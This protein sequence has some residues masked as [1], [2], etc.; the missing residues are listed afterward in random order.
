MWFY[1]KLAWRNIFRN[2]RRTIIASIAI[3]IGLASLIFF[4]ALLIGMK[5]N[6]I[7]SATST[8][9][10]EAQIHRNE[11]RETQEANLTIVKSEGIIKSLGKEEIVEAFTPRTLSFGMLSSPANVNAVVLAGIEPE[12][13]KALSKIDDTI[14]AGDFFKSNNKREII[15]GNK[16]A[17]T[18]EVSLGDRVVVTVSQIGSGDLSQEMF[19]IS[20]IYRFNI[21]EMDSGMAFIRLPKAQE[22]LGLEGQIHEIAIKFKKLEYASQAELP[23]WKKYAKNDNEAA[24]WL[25]IMPQMKA[26]FDMTSISRFVMIF[27]LFVVVLFGII[28]TLFMSLYERMFEFGVLRAIGTRPSGARKLML[29]EAGALGILSITIGIILGLAICLISAQIGFNW[30]GLEL[31]GA[32]IQEVLYPVIQLKQ[33]IFY[34]LSIF[35]F[36]LIIGLYPA[37]IAGKMNVADA[38]RK[39][40]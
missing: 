32:S 30:Q 21:K 9:L 15:I 39:S 8:F 40:L 31:A 38:L 25:E 37:Y 26:V 13:E 18:L 2:K 33:Y 24:G 28:N 36:T 5:D 34:P 19:R 17:E 12:T 16:L 27:I 20:G 11:F 7:K 1:L 35:I 4:D 10:G 22:M 6:L 3:G 23:F 14:I 29:F